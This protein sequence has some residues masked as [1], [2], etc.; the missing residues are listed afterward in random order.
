M[1]RPAVQLALN[2][3]CKWDI[4]IS[5]LLMEGSLL[6]PAVCDKWNLVDN[7]INLLEKASPQFQWC[8]GK[9]LLLKFGK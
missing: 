7:L 8:S 4:V 3:P 1:T 2:C 6:C 5:R 9:Y